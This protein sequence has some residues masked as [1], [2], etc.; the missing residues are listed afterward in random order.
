MLTSDPHHCLLIAGLTAATAACSG[1]RTASTSDESTTSQPEESP[2]ERPSS[3]A[4]DIP[5]EN[6]S[7]SEAR[8]LSA[9]HGLDRLP[10]AVIRLCPGRLS[11]GQDGMP[12]TFSV[13]LNDDTVRP[14]A[15][16][17][18]TTTGERVTPR[19]ATLRPATEPL[20]RRTVLLAGAFGDAAATPRAVEVVGPLEAADGSSLRGLRTE[21]I[22]PLGDGP[23][24]LLAERFAPDREGLAGEC[25]SGTSQVVQ[26]T[27]QGG[28]TGPDGAELSEAQRMAVAITLEDGTTVNPTALADDDPDNFVLACLHNESPA[29][30][31]TVRAGHFHDPG[32]DSNPDTRAEV[33]PGGT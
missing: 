24:V 15:F 8:I 26:L 27:F 25:P 1:S 17:V 13:Q 11:I 32:D 30:S 2:G 3:E 9:Y 33:V 10:P 4:D 12:V 29:T 31:V 5:D 18:V 16:A 20:E 21:E 6:A 28:V 23:R 22:T 14:D 7:P 19:C